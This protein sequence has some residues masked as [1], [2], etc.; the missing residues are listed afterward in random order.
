MTVEPTDP[1]RYAGFWPRLG[2]ILLD[3][4]FMLLP[5]AI[6]VWGWRHYRLFGL[7]YLILGIL[8]GLFYGV[9]LVKR[10]AAPPAN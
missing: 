1:L 3:M 10:L 9:Y 2:A 7:Y 8:F 4:V 6:A 5:A